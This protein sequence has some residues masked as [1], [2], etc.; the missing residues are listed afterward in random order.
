MHKTNTR[1]I[2]AVD[3]DLE[4]VLPRSD[5][6]STYGPFH[7]TPLL[8]RTHPS[9]IVRRLEYRL[10][11]RAARRTPTTAEVV[12]LQFCSPTT[13]GAKTSGGGGGAGL[14]V[15]LDFLRFVR[16]CSGWRKSVGKPLVVAG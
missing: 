7:V 6:S 12:V 4:G 16:V 14:R 11:P 2:I 1:C 13:A 10:K 8:G 9:M 15:H 3:T 5:S